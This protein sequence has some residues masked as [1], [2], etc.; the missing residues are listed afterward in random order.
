MI[1]FSLDPEDSFEKKIKEQ[2]FHTKFALETLFL[3]KNIWE[4]KDATYLN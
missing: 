4:K 2:L 3:V 1:G